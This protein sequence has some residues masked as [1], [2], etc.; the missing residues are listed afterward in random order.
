MGKV[1]DIHHSDISLLIEPTY[2]FV[3]DVDH[4]IFLMGQWM[5][6]HPKTVPQREK[7]AGIG[8]ELGLL[9]PA[10]K[11]NQKREESQVPTYALESELYL[12]WLFFPLYLVLMNVSHS[13]QP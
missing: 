4:L 2:F 8:V 11:E 1:C 10:A 3:R 6:R 5:S 13:T 7:F 9:S 12:F